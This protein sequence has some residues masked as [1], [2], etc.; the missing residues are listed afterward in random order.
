MTKAS[1]TNN[2]GMK[3]YSKKLR[4]IED[5][6]RERRL[7]LKE[8][9][10]LK[11][12]DI[13]TLESIL[14]KGEKD[15]GTDSANGIM[16]S[17]AP[18]LS[19]MS[20]PLLGLVTDFFQQKFSGGNTEKGEPSFIKSILNKSLKKGGNALG[21]AAKELIFGYLKW[22]AVELSYK[23][24]KLIISNKKKKKKAKA[25]QYDENKKNN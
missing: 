9:K 21:S 3:L 19:E 5:V 6:E 25:D 12:E 1:I 14:G 24:V 16:E 11:K 17:L 10:R 4:N 2:A 20:G 7:L 13:F 22:K 23:G 18:A 15:K 8:R